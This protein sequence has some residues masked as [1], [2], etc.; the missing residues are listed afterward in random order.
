LQRSDLGDQPLV[1]S[2]AQ[3]DELGYID[4]HNKN[5]VKTRIEFIDEMP[6]PFI[7]FPDDLGD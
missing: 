4:I 6:E 3:M 7:L 2:R 1:L 5:K